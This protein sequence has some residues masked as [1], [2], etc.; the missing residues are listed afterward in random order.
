MN[1]PDDVTVLLKAINYDHM[2]LAVMNALLER[3][4]ISFDSLQGSV[5]TV[6]HNYDIVKMIRYLLLMHCIQNR[7][8]DIVGIMNVSF[9]RTFTIVFIL[10]QNLC[11]LCVALHPA[12]CNEQKCQ[13]PNWKIIMFILQINEY[14]RQNSIRLLNGC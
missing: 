8:I 12:K 11:K 2:I 10:S 1:I 4:G 7:S 13:R 9:V 5:H 6:R 14:R 3:H